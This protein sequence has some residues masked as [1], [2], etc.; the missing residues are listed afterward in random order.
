MG[1]DAAPP[2]VSR[3][4]SDLATSTGPPRTGHGSGHSYP[5]MREKSTSH[6]PLRPRNSNTETEGREADMDTEY[7]NA[8]QEY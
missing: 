7:V 3:L 2:P 6:A 4:G 8:Y 5:A 1:G